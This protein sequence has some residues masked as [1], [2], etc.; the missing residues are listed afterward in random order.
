MKNKPLR[1]TIKTYGCQ[2]NVA[3]SDL[4]AAHLSS[5]GMQAT[6]QLAE[7]DIV[8]INTCSVRQLAEQK[9]QSYIGRLK[10]YKTAKPSLKVIVAGCMGQRAG[11]ALRGKYPIID[12]VVGARDIEKFPHVFN[13][14][15]GEHPLTEQP[16]SFHP[17]EGDVSVF[18]TIMRGCEN[19]CSYCIVPH[20]RGPEK[21]RPQQEIIDEIAAYV[22][23]G[24]RDVTLLGQNVNSYLSDGMD[25]AELLG[26]VNAIDGLE[27][28]RFM[29]SHPKDLGERLISAMATLP[30]A[31]EHL[32]LPL[33]SG[34]DRILA[35]MNRRYTSADYLRTIEAARGRIP[36]IAFTTDILVGFPG[37]TDDDFRQT[38]RVI[39]AVGYDS[40]FVF[41]YSPRPGTAA[42]Q[43]NDDVSQEV[44]EA[45]LEEVLSC[46]NGFS[47][48]K[49]A[50]LIGTTVDV[51]VERCTDGMCEGHTRTH[52]RVFFPGDAACAGTVVTVRVNDAK[53]NSLTGTLVVP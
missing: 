43:L 48:Q 51:L 35:A 31:C 28:I 5:L 18:V 26:R 6:D 19:F 53:V 45:R 8:I 11:S 4:M 25:F 3:D 41:K 50:K 23:H 21:S 20:V 39:H 49:N 1:F 30:K 16:A 17:A 37:E 10:P 9:A 2:M 36:G 42:A 22:R 34:S 14:W 38:M 27:R 12:F 15:W 44:K 40:L 7:A 47:A 13:A 29:T 52:R 24:G 32:H 33:Q 46:S